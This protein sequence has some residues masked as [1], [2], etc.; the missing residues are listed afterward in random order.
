MGKVLI[1]IPASLTP[2]T[3]PNYEVVTVTWIWGSLYLSRPPFPIT[4]VD[5]DGQGSVLVKMTQICGLE[6]LYSDIA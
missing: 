4:G 5:A 3:V 2:L 6:S 1:Q